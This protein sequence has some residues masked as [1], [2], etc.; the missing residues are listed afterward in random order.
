MNTRIRPNGHNW[1]DVYSDGEDDAAERAVDA[2]F[3]VTFTS[4]E[5]QK[6]LED[7]HVLTT[8]K[9]NQPNASD[10]A[11]RELEAQRRFVAIIEARIARHKKLVATKKDG[12]GSEPS[13]SEQPAPVRRERR[14]HSERTR[15]RRGPTP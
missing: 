11:L 14:S 2:R 13:G 1:D 8:W 7:M 9:R 4:V 6:T 5:G 3:F 10:G 12:V 15:S